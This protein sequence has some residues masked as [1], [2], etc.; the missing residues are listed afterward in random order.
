[1]VGT[2]IG[3][4]IARVLTPILL[5]LP[6]LLEIGRARL[7]QK[8]FFPEHYTIAI[9]AS[10]AAA[11]SFGLL[12][13][14]AW[15]VNSMEREI[16]DLTLRDELTGLYNL[17]GFHLLAEQALRLAQRAQL[18]FTVLFIDVDN[19]KQINDEYGHKLGSAF[20]T[21]TGE[22]LHAL[23]RETDVVGR[24]GGD[25][26][27]VAGQLSRAGVSII[28][29]RIESASASARPSGNESLPL[30]LSIGHVTTDESGYQTLDELL[31]KADKAMYE[32][33]K[34]KKLQAR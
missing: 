19:L 22:L 29:L 7:L 33:K 31:A 24:I 21:E 5:A 13:L 16:H 11:L 4:R 15:R 32:Q 28:A 12:I 6:F 30:S 17:R 10:A 27:A 25:E 2:G 1:L 18:P 26:F 9:L 3:S 34:R 20:L 14:L 8:R 23:F